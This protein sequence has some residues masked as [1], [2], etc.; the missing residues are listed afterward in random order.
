MS[1]HNE[2]SNDLLHPSFVARGDFLLGR[3]KNQELHIT[4]QSQVKDKNCMVLG[5]IAPPDQNL[6]SLLALSHTLKKNGARKCTALL[7]YLAYTRHEHDEP[8]KSQLTALMGALFKASGIDEIVT[9]D[10]HSDA[11]SSLIPLPIISLSPASLFAKKLKE[12]GFI[13]NTIVAPDKGAL[14]RSQEVIDALNLP[15]PLAYIEKKRDSSGIL[16]ADLIGSIGE[17]IVIIDDIW[18][19]GETLLSCSKKLLDLGTK[20]IV[21]MVSHGLFTNNP[22]NNLSKLNIK[23]LYTTNTVAI[24]PP[25]AEQLSITPLLQE[26]L[27]KHA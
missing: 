18:D 9:L 21:I 23:T 12:I 15:I 26:Y 8:N 5:T 16:H 4:L 27:W 13:P 2:M 14:K 3:F 25:F 1:P 10:I 11:A 17:K 7:P 24:H 6:V 19:T 22:F 20:E